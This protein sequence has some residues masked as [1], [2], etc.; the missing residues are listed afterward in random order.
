MSVSSW[1]VPFA[2]VWELR[3]GLAKTALVFCVRLWLTSPSIKE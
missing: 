1:K 3:D 2:E